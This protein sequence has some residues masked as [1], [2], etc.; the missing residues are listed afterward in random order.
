MPRW[1]TVVV[2]ITAGI[3]V[4]LD[5]LTKWVAV[6]RLLELPHGIG[7]AEFAW[8]SNAMVVALNT[9]MPY[10]VPVIP[11]LFDWFLQRNTGGAFSLLDDHPIIITLFSA[12]AIGWIYA[13]SRRIP[14]ERLLVHITFG[15]ILGGGRREP[16]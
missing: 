16:D 5:F 15:L 9:A 6:N 10:R 7:L 12:V 2:F 14:K 13:W 8:P 1:F 4:L 3:V 11:G